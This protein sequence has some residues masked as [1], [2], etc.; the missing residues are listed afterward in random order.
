MSQLTLGLPGQVTVSVVVPCRNEARHIRPFLDSLCHQKLDGVEWEVIIA[1]GMSDDGTRE[2]LDGYRR[3]QGRLR[4]IDNPG[5]IVSSGLNAAIRAA[6]G[7]VIVRMDAHTEYAP[8][9]IRR[10]LEVLE[11]TGADNVGGPPRVKADTFLLRA[12]GAAYHS[13]FAVGGSRSH[14]INYEG[15]VD[16][17]FYGCWRKST[18]LRLGLFDEALV[19]NQDDEL[20]L[21]LTRFG[22]K[23]WQSPGI[24]SWYRPRTTFASLFRQ[25]LQYGFWKV[26]VIRKHGRPASW[27]HL[28]PGA[29]VLVH[30]ALLLSV[31]LA[32]I[33]GQHALLRFSATAWV[34]SAGLYALAC[35]AGALVGARRSAWAVFPV[36]PLL[37]ATYHISYGAGFLAGLVYWPLMGSQTSPPARLFTEITR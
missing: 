4:M 26:A 18:L 34:C 11:R 21:R 5:R 3:H 10:C 17:V 30:F 20:N 9:Y 24:V 31:S 2:V 29:F 1:D 25:Y 12:L 37:F 19:R 33:S 23:V 13:P 16:S 32:A 36:L 22:G 7:D 27:R 8:D 14:D 15:Y 35:L 6:R 28:V